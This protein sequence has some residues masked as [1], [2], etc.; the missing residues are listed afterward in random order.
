MHHSFPPESGRAIRTMPAYELINYTDYFISLL[1]REEYLQW[2]LWTS[3]Y[4]CCWR[5]N[6][7]TGWLAGLRFLPGQGVYCL[8]FS[9]QIKCANYF[10]FAM[11]TQSPIV[12]LRS[13]DTFGTISLKRSLTIVYCSPPNLTVYIQ[14]QSYIRV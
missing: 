8:E 2:R 3:C 7:S 9:S 10:L 11:Q 14:D 6:N 13:Q 1:V 12:Y 4:R 5:T